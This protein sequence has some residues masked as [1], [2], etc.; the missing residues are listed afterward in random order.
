MR[1]VRD[2]QQMYATKNKVTGERSWRVPPQRSEGEALIAHACTLRPSECM[3]A[4]VRETR[5]SSKHWHACRVKQGL[6]IPEAPLIVGVLAC[7]TQA[8]LGPQRSR[9]Q[10]HAAVC[11]RSTLST[12]CSR[13]LIC[14]CLRPTVCLNQYAETCCVQSTAGVKGK[15]TRRCVMVCVGDLC[16]LSSS[17][18]RRRGYGGEG[19]EERMGGG[20]EE[21]GKGR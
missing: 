5:E 6:A 11:L 19:Q 9:T 12:L 16:A 8:V 15:S 10:P 3:H 20:E 13:C 1:H 17:C 18:I 4:H 2:P 21:G 14:D 7:Y